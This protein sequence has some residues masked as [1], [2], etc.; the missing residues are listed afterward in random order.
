SVFGWSSTLNLNLPRTGPT[1][2]RTTASKCV[3]SCT[4]NSSSSGRQRPTFC[5]SVTK[6]HTVSM[7]AGIC[8][9]PLYS[10]FTVLYPTLPHGHGLGA[11]DRAPHLVARDRHVD[12]THAERRQRVDDGVDERRRAADIRALADAFRADRVMRT[13][14]DGFG[15]LPVRRLERRRNQVVGEVRIQVVA[16][17]IVLDLLHERDRKPFGQ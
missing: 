3:A 10:S 4:A 8:S 14:R 2:T 5:G 12:V 1:P 17:V 15:G 13:R 9:L 6:A 16:L 11:P 7:F